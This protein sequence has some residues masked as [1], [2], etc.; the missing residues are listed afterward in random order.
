[1]ALQIRTTV[2]GE[3]KFLDLYRD[4]PVLLSLSFAELQDITKKNSAFSKAF[5]V[6]GSQSNNQIF[7]FFYDI[8]AVPTNFDPNNKFEAI[9]LWDGYEILQGHIRLNG[10]SIANDEIIYQVTF[11]NQIGDLAANIGDKY[12]FNTDLSNLSHPFSQGVTLESQLD[13]NLFVLTGGT[14]Y[15]YQNGKT[16]WGLYNI[17]Y[18]YLTGTTVN[19]DVSP[20]VQFSP[21]VTSGAVTT[22]VPQPGFFDYDQ[23]PVNSFYFKPTIQVKAL[24][25]AICEDAGYEIDSNFFNT[26][27]FEHFYM[28][29]K[30]LDE[31]VYPRN[32]IIPCYR[33]V[34][35]DLTPT[36]IGIYTNPSSGVTCNTLGF[37]ATTDSLTIPGEFAGTYTWRFQFEVLPTQSCDEF[38]QP[39]LYVFFDD[40]TTTTQLYS[41]IFCSGNTTVSFDQTFIFTGTSTFQIYVVGQ[42]LDLRNYSSE[43]ISAPRFI[44]SGSTVD[45]ALEFPDN[46]YTQ[47]DFITSINKYFNL[48]MVPNPDKP[49]SLIVEP[50]IDY[51]GKGR[52]L[53]WTT[54]VDFSQLQSV[55]PTTS[56]LN[57]TLQY[58]FRLDQDYANQD[59]KTQANRTFGTDKFKLGLEYKDTITKFDYLFS[60]PI[61]ITISNSY[62]PLITL[63]S[64]S[65]VKT[66]DKDGQSQQTFVPFKI[67]PKVIFRGPTLPVDNYGYVASSGFTSGSTLC[68]SGI[69]FNY[70]TTGSIF[71][72]DCDGVQQVFDAVVGSNTLTS[73]GDPT[74]LRAPLVVYPPPT[75]TI[76]STG[77]TC[78]GAFFGSPYQYWYLDGVQQ[79]RFNNINR[80]VS[81][82]FAY[83]GFSHYINFRG[84]DK[85]DITPSEFTF[86]SED[87][88]D[89]YYKPYVD[90]L[91]SAENKIYSCKIYL[92]PQEIQDLRWNEKILINNT[93]FRI[94]RITNYNMTEPT[95]CDVELIK[96]TKE[97]PGHRVLYYDLVPCAG[98]SE[99][100]S[101]SDLNFH[102]Y[103]YNDTFVKLYDTDSN[104]LGCYEVQIGVYNSGYTY[105]QYF[106]GTG[107]TSNLVGAYSD[108]GC[109]G[110]TAL[111]LV[112]EEPGIGRYFVYQGVECDGSDVYT[113]ASTEG[114]LES[115]GLI[116]KI[117][118]TGT[119]VTTCVSGITP[120]F[121]STQERIMFSGYPDCSTCNF[122][123]PTPT[124]TPSVTPGLSPTPTSTSIPLTPTP[125]PSPASSYDLYYADE[126]ECLNPGCAFV[127]NNVV[128]AF[129]AGTP[130]N[131]GIFYQPEFGPT[132]Y[133]YSLT[134]IAPSGPGLILITPGFRNCNFSCTN[135]V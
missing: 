44:P 92:Y 34:N 53:D 94:N 73:C 45:Y 119:S 81:Y 30:Y 130:V 75:L 36:G 18:E 131:Y 43:I 91:I 65:K 38:F 117:V 105:N 11:Y 62:I 56:L 54:K 49:R 127:A 58:E 15:S 48:I 39:Y 59:F 113:F 70:S 121:I 16:M 107:F 20:L 27:Y 78:G 4:E 93:Y 51:I 69:T 82:P 128:V 41:S 42:Y 96:L 55:Y 32:A 95:L 120:T 72:N 60:S 33:Y 103:A 118:H 3:Y 97:Y 6:P 23:T 124:P 85:T 14:N 116:Y 134:A 40:G 37:S 133:V 2:L 98:G 12:L 10:V 74:S 86:E 1:M 5:S 50:I 76:T 9:L 57:G 101:N 31:T 28:P 13:P 46:D 64:M 52:T 87:L 89:I 77:T 108:C 17:G 8:N 114:S 80:F 88:Y 61:D 24:Y 111:N 109:S 29:M 126:Y 22:Y 67:L 66:I 63:G 104:Y 68:A 115:T 19:S 132:G 79:D 90:D 122:V 25:N 106:I 112:Q 125:T 100:H 102:L 129:P 47:L 21:I 83:T 84:E 123:Q 99:L 7:N 135:I 35:Q 71:Y 110:R 26:N